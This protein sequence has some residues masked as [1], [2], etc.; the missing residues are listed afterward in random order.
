MSVSE[1]RGDFVP[2]E[3]FTSDEEQQQQGAVSA[4]AVFFRAPV[5]DGGGVGSMSHS[6]APPHSFVGDSSLLDVLGAMDSASW[7]MSHPAVVNFLARH[8]PQTAEICTSNAH[9][10]VAVIVVLRAKFK[11]V[12]KGWH[13]HVKRA[14]QAARCALGDVEYASCKAIIAIY[15]YL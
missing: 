2:P 13:A 5:D 8:L 15:I 10:T 3:T 1:Q 11:H 9:V 6:R 14:A 12:K 4:S 7:S